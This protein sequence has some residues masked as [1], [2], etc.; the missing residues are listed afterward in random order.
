MPVDQ[1]KLLPMSIAQTNKRTRKKTSLNNLDERKRTIVAAALK[2]FRDQGYA[3]TT[4]TQIAQAANLDPTSLY[5][6]FSSKENIVSSFFKF[7]ST[8]KAVE[9]IVNGQESPVV[10]LC[11][12]VVH[13]VRTKCALPFDFMEFET[14]ASQGSRG[15]SALLSL[16]SKLYTGLVCII[17]EGQ[18]TGDFIACDADMRAITILSINDGLQ[19]HFHAK[20]RNQLILEAA[21]Y[22]VQNLTPSQIGSMSAQAAIPGLVTKPQDSL[23]LSRKAKEYY[24]HVMANE[25]TNDLE[26]F[27]QLRDAGDL[28]SD[29]LL[30]TY[31]S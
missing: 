22:Q 7:D 30:A 25:Q 2:L 15:F 14:V 28:L 27:F 24:D 4:M 13:D 18:A 3:K 6:H 16:Y 26:V 21:G 12:L 31:S 20:E 19:H 23:L 10:K 29:E 11:A 9:L 1:S 8:A 5:Y 17:E